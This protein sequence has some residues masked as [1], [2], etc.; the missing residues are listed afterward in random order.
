VLYMG[1]GYR[2]G[3][4]GEGRSFYS[5]DPLT[6]DI[7]TQADVGSNASSIVPDNAIVANPA[8]FDKFQLSAGTSIPNYAAHT[9]TRVYV[10][11]VHGRLW[12]FLTDSPGTAV[13]VQDFGADEPIENPVALLDYDGGT[14][15]K[16]HIYV[17]TGNDR[18]IPAPPLLPPPP[19][20]HLIGLEDNGSDADTTTD[21]ATVLFDFPLPD[22]YRG[23]VQPATAFTDL[24]NARVFLV[25]TRFNP[26]SITG[27]CQSSFDSIIY[28][29]AGQTGIPVYDLNGS[30][31]VDGSDLSKTLTNT[32]VNAV[33]VS[34]GQVTVD[35]GL[36]AQNAP[37]PP[38]PPA[39]G[40]A[41]QQQVF[42][43][44][45]FAG[46]SPVCR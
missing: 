32:R 8:V 40:A 15:E 19:R 28:A 2:T 25:G 9:A 31:A 27:T 3:A 29:V 45:M 20:F 12:K 30:G 4:A 35:Q 5:V 37:P 17:E 10:G 7:L 14:G 39:A 23:T 33:S 11:D 46:G 41:A 43:T 18:R 42:V 24:G 22:R 34:F 13:R 6:G 36:Q 21:N 26:L 16:P 44:G 1:S 38:A